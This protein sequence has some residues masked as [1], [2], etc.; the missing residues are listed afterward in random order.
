SRIVSLW[1][2]VTEVLYALGLGDNLVGRDVTSVVPEE[3]QELPE[4]T[5][6]HDVSAEGVLS[7]NPTLVVGSL[8]N[9]GPGGAL[10]HIRNVGIP[11]VLFED[12]NSVDDIAGRIREIARATGVPNRGEKLATSTSEALGVVLRGLPVQADRPSVAF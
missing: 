10:D 9:S 3:V 2:N 4:V 5:R 11:V 1:G 6:G 8:D 12:P 7:L